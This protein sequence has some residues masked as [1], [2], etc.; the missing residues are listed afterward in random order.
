VVLAAFSPEYPCYAEAKDRLEEGWFSV[1]LNPYIIIVGTP[2]DHYVYFGNTLVGRV[3]S[4]QLSPI[5]KN[6][7][8][9]RRLLKFFNEEV[10]LCLSENSAGRI[11]SRVA[12]DASA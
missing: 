2:D 9:V 4:G 7:Q 3:V 1:A 6:V 10:T 12:P 8:H 5:G 11:G